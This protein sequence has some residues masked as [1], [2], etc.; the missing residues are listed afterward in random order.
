LNRRTLSI[1]IAASGGIG[2]RD[3]KKGKVYNGF[4]KPGQDRITHPGEKFWL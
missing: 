3:R 1:K 4:S 2:Q